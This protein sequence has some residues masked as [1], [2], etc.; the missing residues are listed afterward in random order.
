ML[1]A[2]QT[3]NGDAYVLVIKKGR[4]LEVKCPKCYGNEVVVQ[5]PAQ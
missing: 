3:C 1:G 2:C 5:S 4:R